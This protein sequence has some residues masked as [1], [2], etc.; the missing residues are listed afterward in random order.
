MATAAAGRL[1]PHLHL[2]AAVMYVKNSAPNRC[3]SPPLPIRRVPVGRRQRAAL[4]HALLALDVVHARWSVFA[5]EL[6][7]PGRGIAE[8]S[9]RVAVL[10]GT[11][12][13][14]SHEVK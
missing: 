13:A 9:A 11:P 12:A 3:P 14:S 5:A 6:P 7:P 10:R 4:P 1:R 2:P 8:R